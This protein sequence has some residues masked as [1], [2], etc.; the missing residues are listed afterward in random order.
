MRATKNYHLKIEILFVL[1]C[2]KNTVTLI[3]EQIYAYFELH[4]LLISLNIYKIRCTS[5]IG[6][7]I[8]E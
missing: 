3:L 1:K 2:K 7:D 8:Q 4:R 5:T 6:V